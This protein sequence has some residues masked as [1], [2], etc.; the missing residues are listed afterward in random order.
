MKTKTDNSVKDQNAT[1][2]NNV[3]ANR[4]SLGFNDI[5]GK[6]IFTGD[7]IA[8]N[9]GNV[10]GIVMYGEYY[11]IGVNDNPRNG[12]YAECYGI[13][14]SEVKTFGLEVVS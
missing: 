2:D 5:N 8:D 3:L 6:E 12:F 13:L 11:Q 7:T 14:E 9:K 1:C 10:L 4:L